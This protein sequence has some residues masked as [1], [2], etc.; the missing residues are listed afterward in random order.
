MN[1]FL[2]YSVVA[3]F[4]PSSHNSLFVRDATS[5]FFA[6]GK[7]RGIL[8]T[9]VSS[10]DMGTAVFA[11][12]SVDLL[13]SNVPQSTPIVDEVLGIPA[14]EIRARPPAS[15]DSP[16]TGHL[17]LLNLE[18]LVTNSAFFADTL[19]PVIFP[20]FPHPPSA[21]PFDCSSKSGG[22]LWIS[23]QI[24][25]NLV[26]PSWANVG[27]VNRLGRPYAAVLRRGGRCPLPLFLTPTTSDGISELGG[28]SRPRMATLRNYDL[29]LFRAHPA[30]IPHI[31]AT[32]WI[33]IRKLWL[34][35]PTALHAV[36]GSSDCFAPIRWTNRA[37][38]NA[39]FLGTSLRVI[40]IS[41]PSIWVG[42]LPRPFWVMSPRH[43]IL[44]T[45]RPKCPSLVDV[46]QLIGLPTCPSPSTLRHLWMR[47][48]PRPRSP[49]SPRGP[50]ASTSRMPHTRRELAR[51]P[52][53]NGTWNKTMLNLV[54]AFAFFRT[55]LRMARGV[56]AMHRH[57]TTSRTL[58]ATL[59]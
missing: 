54:I 13:R 22:W 35:I 3:A 32:F 18:D 49:I 7:Q 43:R 26:A 33:N 29:P 20:N 24:R 4:S 21:S 52:R 53:W 19:H 23:R 41:L 39:T 34:A 27:L 6:P 50:T 30:G 47:T 56:L 59:L 14:R 12:L 36:L 48:V 57:R 51:T 28:I 9:V 40:R 55:F 44:V 11:K 25:G 17:E 2:F 46:P 38:L 8:Y 42:V 31:C 5:Y 10:G 58:I 37:P 1:G 15:Q 45:S 16:D